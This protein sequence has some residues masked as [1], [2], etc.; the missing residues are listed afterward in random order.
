MKAYKI[1]LVVA[2]AALIAACG[3]GGDA[4]TPPAGGGSG[5]TGNPSNIGGSTGGTVALIASVPAP[6]YSGLYAAEKVAVFNRLNDDLHTCGFG[7]KRQS[8]QLDTSAQGHS[9][10]IALNNSFSHT[11]NSSLP[12]FTG[13]TLGVRLTAAGYPW[14]AGSEVISY[15]SYGSFFAGG[16]YPHS[17][18]E[19]SAIVGLK[20]LYNA[21]YH[22]I[23]L[24]RGHREMGIGVAVRD[25]SG[26]GNTAFIK[27]VTINTGVST[28]DLVQAAAADA[29]QVFPCDGLTDISPMYAGE[30]PEPF[31]ALNRSTSA[32][33]HLQ[34]LRTAP[35]SVLSNLQGT[36]TAH[37]GGALPTTWLNSSNDP[38]SRLTAN[39][40]ILMPTVGMA[41]N[42]THTVVI[43]GRSTALVV[44]CAVG[45]IGCVANPNGDF[46]KTVTWRTG[47][48]F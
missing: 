22:L 44:T 2:C 20:E 35:G 12:G 26:G 10:Y 45:A 15:P 39:E 14:I 46:L 29:L 16:I 9:N 24:L 32:Y 37:L 33:G 23:G 3:G 25:N 31:P 17:A 7:K 30:T 41:S 21:P 38:N 43:S 18:T 13:A 19:V 27:N 34:Y 36:V 8:A 28:S 40:A 4:G 47:T 48:V 6:S 5:G 11:Q 42:T 1:G